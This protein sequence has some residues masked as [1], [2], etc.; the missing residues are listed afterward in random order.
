MATYVRKVNNTYARC[1]Q[2]RVISAPRNRPLLRSGMHSKP[3]VLTP[4]QYH[5]VTSS[6]P[7]PPHEDAVIPYGRDKWKREVAKCERN[8]LKVGI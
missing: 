2:A 6:P 1:L 3:R 8:G 5:L 7:S 4:E